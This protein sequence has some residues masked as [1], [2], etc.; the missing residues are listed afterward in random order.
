[1][2]RDECEGFE[3]DLEA[4]L[5]AWTQ[6]LDGDRPALAVLEHL[7][8][9]HLGDRGGG[10][11][12]A[13]ASK[14]LLDRCAERA[15]HRGLGLRL[16]ERRHTVLQAFEIARERRA[17]DIGPGRQELAELD[18]ARAEPCQRRREPHGAR[19]PSRGG[20]AAGRRDWAL[21]QSAEAQHERDRPREE[22]RIEQPEHPLARK[23]EARAGEPGKMRGSE[24]HGGAPPG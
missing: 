23:Y 4:A 1:V 22:H 12:R 10:D 14:Y 9:M 2:E 21:D 11:R 16:R 3:I 15:R 13:E 6:N 24:H 8:A 18:V 17:D 20:A 19:G 5:D 7:G